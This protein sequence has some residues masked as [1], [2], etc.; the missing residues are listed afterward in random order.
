MPYSQRCPKV[1]KWCLDTFRHWGAKQVEKGAQRCLLPL[2]VGT[3]GTTTCKGT[4]LRVISGNKKLQSTA[5][6]WCRV[7]GVDDEQ[8]R[9]MNNLKVHMFSWGQ[10]NG[11]KSPVCEYTIEAKEPHRAFSEAAKLY[12]D[13]HGNDHA[14]DGLIAVMAE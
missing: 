6:T 9:E 1:P 12:K 7:W 3:V 4:F 13:Q 5:P 2:R 11:L 10:W 14:D 8:R